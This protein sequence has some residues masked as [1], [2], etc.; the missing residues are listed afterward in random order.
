MSNISKIKTKNLI[1]IIMCIITN[2]PFAVLS[3]LYILGIESLGVYNGT[4]AVVSFGVWGILFGFWLGF[5]RMYNT[6]LCQALKEKEE[7]IEQHINKK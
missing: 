4:V 3:I 1:F 7:Y 6:A 2:I 5:I